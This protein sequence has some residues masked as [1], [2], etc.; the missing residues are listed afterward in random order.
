MKTVDNNI[1]QSIMRIIDCYLAPYVET[2]IKK[3]QPDEIKNLDSM[4][5]Q[6]FFFAFVWAVG[7]TTTLDGRMKF[8]KWVR[9]N[10]L[11]NL[12]FA[13][14]ED[15][16]VYD[17]KF[18]V[19]KKDWANWRDTVPEYTVEIKMSYNEILVPTVDSIRMK[20]FTK[21]LVMNGKHALT[22]GPTGTGKSVNVA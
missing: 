19:E 8:D 21:L 3:I 5:N 16:L 18:D 2:E 6:L 13:F 14:P 12:G 22:P 4:I 15:K 17:Y 1:T 20:Y 7:V 9:Q 11:A 10:V